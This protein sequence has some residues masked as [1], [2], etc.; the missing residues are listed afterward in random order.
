MPAIIDERNVGVEMNE[1]MAVDNRRALQ[2]ARVF[3]ILLSGTPGCGKTS[4]IEAT[5]RRLNGHARVGAIVCNR[6]AE[7]DLIR[8]ERWCRQVK[9]ID[10]A[11]LSAGHVQEALSRMDLSGIDLLFMECV[12]GLAD[13]PAA[14]LGQAARVGVFSVSGGDDKAAEYPQRVRASEALVLTKTDLLLHV[15]FDIE[16]F[17]ADVA[18][19][20][21]KARLIEVS[22]LQGEGL[23][24]WMK[25]VIDGL[26]KYRS[27]IQINLPDVRHPEAFLG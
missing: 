27:P 18:H 2:K 26:V 4:L 21:P 12:G 6:A 22:V 3:S 17:R 10:A 19:L 20:N 8:L 23:D 14:D 5:T 16:A 11:D 1:E 7:R 25:W 24:A 15:P 9:A 13:P